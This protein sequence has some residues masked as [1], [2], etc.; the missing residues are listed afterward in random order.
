MNT[1]LSVQNKYNVEAYIEKM[2]RSYDFNETCL[3][4]VD[5][6]RQLKKGLVFLP[7]SKCRK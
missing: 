7:L 2:F 3:Q 1:A 5:K 4:L 6:S